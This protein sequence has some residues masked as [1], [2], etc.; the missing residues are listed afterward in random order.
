MAGGRL[1]RGLARYG[2][3]KTLPSGPTL[4]T[5]TGNTPT[6]DGHGFQI[7]SGDGHRSTMADGN[8]IRI[9]AGCGFPDTNGRAL[10]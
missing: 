10:G 7:L 3:T 6:M 5:V 2:F 1:I 9:M 4:L 8:M